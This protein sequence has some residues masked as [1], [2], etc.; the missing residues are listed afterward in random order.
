MYYLAQQ[1]QYCFPNLFNIKKEHV[2]FRIVWFGMAVAAAV[3]V[4]A[5]SCR[6]LCFKFMEITYI[7]IFV[8]IEYPIVLYKFD[9]WLIG[10]YGLLPIY[11]IIYI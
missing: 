6:L 7:Y 5:D 2:V 4:D 3:V 10:H 8:Y 9:R 1:R 11:C